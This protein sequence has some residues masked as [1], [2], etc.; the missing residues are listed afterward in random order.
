M[1]V[2]RVP[3]ASLEPGDVVWVEMPTAQVIGSEQQKRRPWLVLSPRAILQ[4][5]LALVH[6]VPF[7]TKTDKDPRPYRV[8]VASIELHHEDGD[9]D[10]GLRLTRDEDRLV[11]CDQARTLSEQRIIAVAGRIKN[12]RL[13]NDIRAGVAYVFGA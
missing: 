13:L 3:A 6:A 9:L 10:A 11:L 4:A 2:P 7:T 8:F 1:I 5:K 12:K